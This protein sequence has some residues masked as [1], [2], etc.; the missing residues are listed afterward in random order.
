MRRTLQPLWLL[1]LLAVLW[2]HEAFAEKKTVCSITVN[3][4]DEKEAFQRSLPPEKF[5]FIE[6]VERGRP[7]WLASACQQKIRCDVLVVSGHFDGYNEFYSDRLGVHEFLPVDEL[8]RASCSNSCSGLFSQLKEVYLFG[9]NTLNPEA[10]KRTSDEVE[11]SLLRS[12]YSRADAERASRV[13]NAMHSESSRDRMRLIFK[14]VRVIYGFSAKAPLGPTAASMLNGYFR[15]GG[16][17]E[18]GSGR[19]SPGLRAHFAN[20]SMAAASGLK[21]SEP[22]ATVRGDVCQFSDADLTAAPKL[23]F[24]HQLMARPMAEVRVYFDRIERYMASLSDAQRQSPAA[25]RALDEIARDRDARARYLDFARDADEPKVRARMIAVAERLGWLSPAEKREE[26][27]RLIDDELA[28]STI[29]AG[30]VD[31]ACALNEDR[32]LDRALDRLRYSSAGAGKLAQAAVLACLGG[33]E[34]RAQVLRALTSPRDEDV[35]IAQVYLRYHPITDAR[36]LRTITSDIARMTDPEAKVRSLDALA[37]QNVSDRESLEELARLFPAA[38]SPGV[39]VAIAGVL[40]RSDARAIA[41]PELVQTLQQSRLKAS[42]GND[43]IDVLIRQLQAK[44]D[45]P[46]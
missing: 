13:L 40:I 37:S 16:G 30:D 14:D 17:A 5:Q 45:P 23:A 18:I 1:A 8:E 11:R 25:A 15:S 22:L 19:P 41:T 29:N 12:G 2:A 20:S 27:V 42:G 28:R 44:I 21:D 7:D 4:S 26:L 24:I 31:L 6:L 46:S 36:A 43:L 32:G 33:A 38:E 34:A 39:Q 35:Q 9:C 10:L 3:S